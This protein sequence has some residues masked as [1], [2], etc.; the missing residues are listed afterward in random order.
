MAE[1]RAVA[2]LFPRIGCL[3]PVAGAA[4]EGRQIARRRE[5]S[6]GLLRLED[7]PED[8]AMNPWNL[9]ENGD[10]TWHI[11]EV[12]RSGGHVVAERV[13]NEQLEQALNIVRLMTD[14]IQD[15]DE[16]IKGIIGG[17]R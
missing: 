12:S 17:E 2:G 9:Y 14:D 4:R 8:G 15:A 11:L 1:R 6:A 10:G 16:F 3:D 13:T 7:Q 5:P